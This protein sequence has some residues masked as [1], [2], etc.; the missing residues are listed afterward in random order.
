MELLEAEGKMVATQDRE[1]MTDY[2]NEQNDIAAEAKEKERLSEEH[3]HKHM[4]FL[5]GVSPCLRSRL[6][7]FQC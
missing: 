4:S 6:V 1:K 3:L 5:R 2:K 7:Q